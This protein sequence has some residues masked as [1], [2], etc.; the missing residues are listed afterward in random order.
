MNSAL[1]Q[2][3]CS[4]KFLYGLVAIDD[5]WWSHNDRWSVSQWYDEPPFFMMKSSLHH[6]R[7]TESSDLWLVLSLILFS[8][9]V[10]QPVTSL[11]T[12]SWNFSL[13]NWQ[14]NWQHTFRYN[15][16]NRSSLPASKI[17]IEVYST[18]RIKFKDTSIIH[19]EL[20]Y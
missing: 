4:K 3:Y 16:S 9:Q 12:P 8:G 13:E 19:L 5:K 20:N 6:E 7:A 18:F 17:E 15:E 10:N 1:F 11:A 2:R 14:V